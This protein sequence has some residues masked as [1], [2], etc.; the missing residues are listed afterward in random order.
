MVAWSVVHVITAD[1]VVMPA[2]ATAEITGG[3]AAAGVTGVGVEVTGK[4]T[5]VA[6]VENE[7]VAEVEEVLAEFAETTS[8]L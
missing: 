4:R 1:V 2:A 8:K 3:A 7:D 6:I 5:A